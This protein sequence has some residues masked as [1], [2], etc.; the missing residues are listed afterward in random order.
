M[1]NKDYFS[2]VSA[3]HYSVYNNEEHY[4]SACIRL[5]CSILY[6]VL[7][8]IM[9]APSCR[10]FEAQDYKSMRGIDS[11]GH[12]VQ[13]NSL[14]TFN[15]LDAPLPLPTHMRLGQPFS[16]PFA[17]E[18]NARNT[19]AHFVH[20]FFLSLPAY[21]LDNDLVLTQLDQLSHWRSW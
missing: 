8:E 7:V 3:L 2:L 21:T 1:L 10:K 18:K 11:L 4:P 16:Q 19:C 9:M 14:V 12:D 15:H 20:S 5:F 6:L 13:C 17:L